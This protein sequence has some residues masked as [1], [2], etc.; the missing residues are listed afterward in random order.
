MFRPV[1]ASRTAA[2]L[3]ATLSLLAASSARGEMDRWFDRKPC[4]SLRIEKHRS[5]ANH[6]VVASVT[7]DDAEYLARLVAAI[8]KLPA[9]G[10]LMIKAAGGAAYTQLYFACGGAEPRRLDILDGMLKTPST[11]F[12][13][14]T[15]AEAAI[16]ADLDALVAPAI[17]KAVPKVK[18]LALRFDGFTLTYLGEDHHD[19]APATVHADVDHFELVVRGKK[20]P[21]SITSGQMPPPPTPF[22]VGKAKRVLQSYETKQGVR[23]FPTHFQVTK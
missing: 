10:K 12:N 7:I 18:G 8:E 21:I 1:I 20:T 23:L 4:T 2:L 14:T 15:P 9:E 11:G 22:K 17:G 5:L 19:G 3:V 16:V 6:E 13:D